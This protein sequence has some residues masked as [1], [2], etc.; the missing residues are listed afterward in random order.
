MKQWKWETV[1]GNHLVTEH[2]LK[3]PDVLCRYWYDEPP[4]KDA[5]LIAAAPELLGFMEAFDAAWIVDFPDGPTEDSR[6]GYGGSIPE[7]HLELWRKVR[8]I[9]VKVKGE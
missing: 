4:S 8:E 3:G 6:D 9:I 1:Q 2:T 5:R 7:H